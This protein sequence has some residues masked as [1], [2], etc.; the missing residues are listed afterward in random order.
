MPLYRALLHLYPAA[1][2]HEYGEEMCAIFRRRRQDSAGIVGA[3]LL[4]VSTF[5]E[6]LFHAA[7]VHCDILRQDLRYAAR[8]L[9]RERGFALTAIV[10]VALGIG[11]NTA[12][13]SLTDYV[14]LR[15]LPFADADRLVKLWEVTPGYSRMEASPANYRDWK[16]MSRSFEA[17]G[18]FTTIA[19]NLVGQ[20][21]PE[22]VE[23][24]LVSADLFPLLG[25]QPMAGRLFTAA[26]D[27]AGAPAT[28]LLSYALWQSAFGGDP[29][30]LGTRA[31]LNDEPYVIVGIMPR[32]FHF[33]TRQDE[34]WTPERFGESDYRDRADNY[35]Q[36]VGKLRPGTTLE[37]ARAE[38]RV[39]A[40]QLERT[41]PSENERTGAVA[42]S[43]R[44][45]LSE[46]SRLLL[47]ALVGA[48]A[49]VLLIAC[50]NLANLL[51][52]RALARRR[53]LA[54]RTALGGGRERL[55]RQLATESVLLAL[56]GGA[57]GILT[58][59]AALPLLTRLVPFALPV[60]A[61]PSLD[62][63]VLLFAAALT[64]LTG[65]AFG[66]LPAM[67][68]CRGTDFTALRE[69]SRAGGG[70]KE[71][72]R[73]ALVTAEV[74]A[75]VV[76][77]IGA[78][79]LMRAMWRL[80]AV[81]P[82]F[83]AEGVITLRTA[84]SFPRYEQTARRHAFYSRVLGD[85]RALPGVDNAAYIS[86]LPMTMTGGIFP[87]TVNGDTLTRNESRSA[88]MR[89]VTPGF[90]ATL[91]IPLLAGRDVDESD[92]VERPFAAVVSE[93]FVKRYWPHDNPLGRHFQFAFHDRMVVGVVRDIRVRG[94]DRSSEPQVYLPYRQMGDGAFPFYAPK[95]LVVHSNG[96]Q[97]AVLAAVQKIIRG[98]D[99]L[100]PISDVRPLA[101]IVAEET[102]PR[103][104]QIRVL[105]AF[106]LTAF[107][108]AAV[109]IHG[110]LAFAVS[111]R[112]R[113]IGVRIALGAARADILRMVL[114]DGL[115]AAGVGILFGAL[116]GY[117]AGS[118]LKTL[119]AGVTPADAP[120][121]AAAAAL[122]LLMTL[123]GSLAPALR[124]LAIDPTAAMREE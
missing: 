88:S 75:S 120:T 52:A 14:L 103:L 22:R 116:L 27:R 50:T 93:S 61:E 101:A 32:D 73:A 63:R 55:V 122:A 82:G 106:A 69:G 48:A 119:L 104:A 6:V 37:A 39:V 25:T 71:R 85:I 95:D 72:L 77:L 9:S 109:G 23:G 7:A 54:M 4:W 24:A 117:A 18:S 47:F 62:G 83:R 124:A 28:V 96:Q 33:P 8:A 86:F 34:F 45:E 21:E 15:P 49:C 3:L 57:L 30:V 51:L 43:L 56:L 89:F 31:I 76:L 68:I 107:L 5:V 87:A 38:M 13:F 80:Q 97:A 94:L 66:V 42:I 40:A 16:R 121:Y 59:R 74:T 41:Y 99:A 19:T 35:L 91:R 12:V 60:G 81:D 110:L 46:Q 78:G 100:Q 65:A 79:L 26:E 44:D 64:L 2:R 58:A 11:A 84:L 98:A 1:F 115:R 17:M 36:V 10:V 113:E 53:E 20:G 92:T 114:R 123:A 70:R 118:A 102:A 111:Q 29:G 90:F 67:R 108:L 105:A 112:T